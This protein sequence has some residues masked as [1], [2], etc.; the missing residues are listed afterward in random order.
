MQTYNLTYTNLAKLFG[1]NEDELRSFCDDTLSNDSFIYRQ[2]SKEERDALLLRV[3]RRIEVEKPTVVGPH[4]KI[5]WEQGWNENLEAFQATGY[6]LKS[7]I[8]RYYKKN[9]PCR[10]NGDYVLPLVPDFVYRVTHLFRSWLFRRYF[11]EVPTV[12]EFGCGTGHHLVCLAQLFPQKRLYGFDWVPA[13]QRILEL[14]RIHSGFDIHAR[15][16]DFMQPPA[17]E[18]IVPGSGVFTFGALEQ[19]GGNHEPFLQFLLRHRP[20][21]CINVEGIHEL[22][23][24]N[25]LLDY[26][27]LKYHDSRGYLK[28][29]L[30][31]LRQLEEEGKIRILDVHHQKFGNIYDDP[32]SYIIWKIL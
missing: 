5:D 1:A 22:Y 17:G 8:P 20:G 27:A 12:Y 29:Y 23:S 14:L 7:L 2:L 11:T 31:R 19:I 26:L 32:H 30:T 3:I 9:A 16:F 28:N 21:I 18:V 10:L 25:E 15:A 6:N 13:S 24:Q 4:R